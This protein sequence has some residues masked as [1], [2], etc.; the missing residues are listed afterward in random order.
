VAYDQ[1]PLPLLRFLGRPLVRYHGV[2]VVTEV[3][4]NRGT[5]PYLADHLLDGN[6]L[7]PAV[8]GLEAMAQVATA[9]TGYDAVPV[10][11]DAAFLRPIVV[12]PAGQ[13]TVRI[14]ATVTGN[15]AVDVSIR[16]AETG[17]AVEHFRARLRY[18]V[19]GVPAGPPEQVAEGLPGV[20]LDPATD[21]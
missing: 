12:P 18:D 11:E 5:D 14:A 9:V 16:S 2:E 7:L 15:A 21:L 3:D 10:I 17:F 19:S 13:P 6:L 4:L 20:P 1:P 8:F